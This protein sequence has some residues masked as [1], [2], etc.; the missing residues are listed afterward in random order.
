[1]VVGLRHFARSVGCLLIAGGIGTEAE[2]EMLGTLEI[3]LAR[4]FLLGRPRPVADQVGDGRE[5]RP[6]A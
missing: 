2:L 5:L 1:M 4:G 3:R 6:G